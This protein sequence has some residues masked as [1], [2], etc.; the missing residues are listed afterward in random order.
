VPTI[1]NAEKEEL[2]RPYR[3]TFS[4][5]DEANMIKDDLTH[6]DDK[7]PKSL[8]SMLDTRN[9]S[10][11]LLRP[12]GQLKPFS[13]RARQF[14]KGT[15]SAKSLAEEPNKCYIVPPSLA[16]KEERDAI[17]ALLDSSS[18]VVEEPTFDLRSLY[19]S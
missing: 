11:L 9:S 1:S 14:I 3:Q 12:R 16:N 6:E 19:F 13:A 18:S 4:Y 10:R 15:Q 2:L 8:L 5:R 7:A 17:I